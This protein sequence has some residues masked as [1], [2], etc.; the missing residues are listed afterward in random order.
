MRLNNEAHTS[1]VIGELN[2]LKKKS[3][4]DKVT[5]QSALYLL[6]NEERKRGME[7]RLTLSDPSLKQVINYRNTLNQSS[8]M[9]LRSAGRYEQFRLSNNE[10]CIG[11]CL[12]YGLKIPI[13]Q[14]CARCPFCKNNKAGAHGV[15]GYGH[16]FIS[17]CMTDIKHQKYCGQLA[18]PH[19]IHDIIV[20]VLG[21]ICKHA[22][23]RTILEPRFLLH[24]PTARNQLR[25]DV[26][27]SFFV[28]MIRRIHAL[29]LAICCPF[30]GSQSGKLTVDY[31]MKQGETALPAGFEN[32]IANNRKGEKV[33]KYKRVCTERGVK[34]VP[35]I[36]YSTGKIHKDGMSFLRSL[37]KYGHEARQ[38]SPDTLLKYY[39]K[40]LNFALI[41]QVSYTIYAK[42]IESLNAGRH[43]NVSTRTAIRVGNLCADEIAN[44]PLVVDPVFRRT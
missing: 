8:G 5:F 15:D 3:I 41:K 31:R 27:A 30:G 9:W 42:S 19:A 6:K 24:Q 16:H 12:R 29:D 33:K 10:F 26:E 2:R 23:A 39:I 17:S 37:A 25:P 44:P 14:E 4:K 38:I 43:V 21:R 40:L 32:R 22:M 35:F 20:E 28:N 7:E 34:F 11:L 1:D 18:Q 36:M 13:I